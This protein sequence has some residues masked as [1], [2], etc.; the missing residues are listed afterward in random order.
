MHSE[1]V[2]GRRPAS[3]WIQTGIDLANALNL[4]EKEGSTDFDRLRK[5]AKNSGVPEEDI[6]RMVHIA[7]LCVLQDSCP[8]I[9]A[10]IEEARLL[11]ESPSTNSHMVGYL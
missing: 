1:G 7:M 10:R 3:Y 4:I 2:P 8:D 6:D 5:D 11:D 9:I